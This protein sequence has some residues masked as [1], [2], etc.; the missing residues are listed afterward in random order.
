MGLKNDTDKIF[1][2]ATL[3]DRKILV[4]LLTKCFSKDNSNLKESKKH[5]GVNLNV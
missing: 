2:K 4:I 1:H 5:F 3:K